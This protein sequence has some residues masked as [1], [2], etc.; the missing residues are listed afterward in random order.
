MKLIFV[1]PVIGLLGIIITS[2]GVGLIDYRAGIIVGGV[3]LVGLSTILPDFLV[4]LEERKNESSR[5]VATRS[6]Q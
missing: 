4:R 2:I 1:G 3:S 5:Q 6:P